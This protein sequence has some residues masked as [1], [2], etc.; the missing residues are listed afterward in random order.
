MAASSSSSPEEKSLYSSMSDRFLLDPADGVFCVALDWTLS[1]IWTSSSSSSS[2]SV[3]R[4]SSGSVS[5]SL[6]KFEL[7]LT[8]SLCAAVEEGV[9]SPCFPRP[10]NRFSPAMLRTDVFSPAGLFSLAG[11]ML[12]CMVLCLFGLRDGVPSV[13]LRELVRTAPI[14]RS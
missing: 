3:K 5:G 8:V 14:S 11:V 10:R 6:A 1:N 2:S 4:C 13:S 12:S 9:L 7:P